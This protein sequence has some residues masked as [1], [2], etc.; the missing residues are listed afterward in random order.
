MIGGG[1]ALPRVKP[2]HDTRERFIPLQGRFV[3]GPAGAGSTRIN[4]S[5]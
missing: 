2:G 5:T 1:R 4:L 3:V